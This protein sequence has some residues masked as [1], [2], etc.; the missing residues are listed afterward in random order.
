MNFDEAILSHSQWRI[1]LQSVIAGTSKEQL[2]P[3]VVCLD[4]KCAL[5]QWIYGEARIYVNLPEYDALRS[6]HAEFHKS[7]AQVLRLSTAGKLA[8]ATAIMKNG[9][10]QE[11]SLRTISA[12]RKLRLKIAV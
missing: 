4:D 12:I 11:A 10:F 9:A 5:G 2:D 3:A 7:A 1:R 8:E 6:S